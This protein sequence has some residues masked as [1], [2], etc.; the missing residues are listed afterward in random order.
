MPFSKYLNFLHT[1]K[2]DCKTSLEVPEKK[3]RILY[4]KRPVRE[5]VRSRNHIVQTSFKK[6]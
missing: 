4:S 5:V 3:S 6:K 1:K 2:K